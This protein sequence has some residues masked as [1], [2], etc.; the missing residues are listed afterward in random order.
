MLSF[1][2]VIDRI[3][4]AYDRQCPSTLHITARSRNKR[5]SV[6][7]WTGNAQNLPGVI[8]TCNV[9]TLQSLCP[10]H[11][12]MLATIKLGFPNHQGVSSH[13][14]LIC[15]LLTRCI[16]CQDFAST[17]ELCQVDLIERA[18]EVR[19][20]QDFQRHPIIQPKSVFRLRP[21]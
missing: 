7:K 5:L 12:T 11:D 1:K 19:N 2:I 8:L 21:P 17:L 20:E 3:I 6:Y 14:I 16:A 10:D 4:I 18:R 13:L 15:N 9:S